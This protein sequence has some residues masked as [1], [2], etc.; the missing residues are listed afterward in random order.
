M[1]LTA[2][3]EA[4]C[5]AYIEAN[6]ASEAYRRAY[7]AENMKQITVTKRA[8][9]L[10]ARGDIGGM[11]KTIKDKIA[12]KNLVTVDS[13]VKELCTESNGWR[14]HRETA[15][16]RM[17]KWKFQSESTAKAATGAAGA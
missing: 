15:K 11:V 1:K 2:K 4:L 10:L 12:A 6:N 13:L 7:N 5:L 17:L 14:T 3:Q 8:S 16:R 9:E